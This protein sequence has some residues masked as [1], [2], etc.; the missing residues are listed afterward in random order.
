MALI[1]LR[2]QLIFLLETMIRIKVRCFDD[3]VSAMAGH[4]Q[5]NGCSDQAQT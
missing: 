1:Q 3:E 2:S 5:P 4:C